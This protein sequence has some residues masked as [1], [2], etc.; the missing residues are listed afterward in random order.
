MEKREQAHTLARL[1][2]VALVIAAI[3][4]EVAST[5]PAEENAAMGPIQQSAAR[6]KRCDLLELTFDVPGDYENPFDP[7]QIAVDG[8]FTCPSGNEIVAPAFFYQDYDRSVDGLVETLSP[9]GKPVWNIR[10]APVEEGKYLYHVV[11]KDRSGARTS[12]EGSFECLPSDSHGYLRVSKADPHYFEFDDGTPYLA[13]GQN[14]CWY[15]NGHGTPDYDR[16]FGR[17]AENGENYARLWMSQMSFG[18]ETEQLGRYEQDHAWQLDYVLR[19]AEQKGIYIKLCFSA[20]RNFKKGKVVYDKAQGGPCDSPADFIKDEVP[21]R[22]FKN[23]L[24][25]IVARWGYSPHIMGWEL[26]NEYNTLAGYKENHQAYV[27]WSAEMAR[28]LKSL[29]PWE[30][31]TVQSLGSCNFDDA[32]WHL[33]EMDWAQM[34]GYYYFNEAMKRDAKDMAYFVPLWLNAIRA[35]GKP[36]LFAEFGISAQAKNLRDKDTQGDNLHDGIWSSVMAGGAGTAMLWWWDSEVDAMDQYGQFKALAQFAA[37]VPWT[38][39]G[40]MPIVCDASEGLRCYS[41][42]G[43]D[44]RLLWIQ[45]KRHTWWNVVNGEKIDPVGGGQVTLDR[46]G[47]DLKECAVEWWDTHTGEIIKTEKPGATRNGQLTLNVPELLS[48]IAAKVKLGSSR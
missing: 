9:Q 15:R 23:R 36:A 6:V 40:F 34:H 47:K 42:E 3:G 7:E 37:G 13:I 11:V 22:L 32:L 45:N 27:D 18:I 12:P 14:V 48:D 44:L 39:Q 19:L 46:M 26:W 20:W 24:R 4:I 25:Y 16:W 8:H 38:T 1:V 28:Y 21:R 43:R 30:H 17:M 31:M 29:D 33:P 10:F 41:L 5:F 35:F 2:G